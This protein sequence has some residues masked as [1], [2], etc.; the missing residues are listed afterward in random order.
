MWV[1]GAFCSRPGLA[2]M[3]KFSDRLCQAISRRLATFRSMSRPEHVD[4]DDVADADAPAAGKL[5]IERYQRRPAVVG[6]PPV[7]G[8]DRG[9]RMAAWRHRSGRGRLAAPIAYQASPAPGPP[10]R[11]SPPRCGRAGWEPGA[12]PR[13]PAAPAPAIRNCGNWL[14]WMS[15]KKKLGAL[16]GSC[17]VISRCTFPSM[18]ATAARVDRPRPT[19][20]SISGVAAPGRCRLARP[21]R[22]GWTAQQEP[23]TSRQR[24]DDCRQDGTGPASRGR[25]RRTTT[26]SGGRRR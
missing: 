10:A 12:S 13:H 8:D 14:F 2:T 17:S 9:C 21:S 7:S 24:H 18:S 11:R 5:G 26:R 19:E 23:G 22:R 15:T 25:R 4:P 6:W 20:T 3:A 1:C 16:A